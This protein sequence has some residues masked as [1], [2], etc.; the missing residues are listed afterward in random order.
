MRPTI[1][2]DPMP[3][4]IFDKRYVMIFICV[5]CKENYKNIVIDIPGRSDL[6]KLDGMC[7]FCTANTKHLTTITK[8]DFISQNRNKKIIEIEK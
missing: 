3:Q 6:S 7:F 5:G 4:N 8:S 2:Y 1:H